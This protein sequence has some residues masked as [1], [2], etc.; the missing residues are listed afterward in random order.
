MSLQNVCICVTALAAACLT[1]TPARADVAIDVIGDYEVSFEGLLQ[2]DANWFDNDVVDLNGGGSG[3]GDDSE[4]ELRRAELI[5]KGKGT[6][7]DWVIG[8]DAKADKFLDVNARYKRGQSFFQLGQYK[9]PNSLEELS[10]TRHNDFIAKSMTTNL[11]GVGRR[12]GVAYGVD[13]GDYGFTVSAFDR[14]LTRNLA[15]GQGFGARG[16]FAPIHDDVRLLHLGL[17]AI[18][19]KTDADALRLRARPDAD[20][21]TARLIDTGSFTNTDRQ[22][23][24]GVEGLFVQG[25]FKLQGEYMHSRVKRD[26]VGLPLTQPA[27]DFDGS[28]W[29][30]Q[31]LWNLTG[32]TWGYKGGVP[33][34]PFPN[35]PSRGMWQL[36]ARVDAADL[37]DGAV[38]GGEAENLTLGVN[39]YWRSNFKVQLN[40]VL[41]SSERFSS[42]LGAEIDDD[43]NIVE[44]RLQFYW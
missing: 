30:L 11:F 15:E 38:F 36:A 14:E 34:V 3:N 37:D 39:W 13:T 42:A 5:L 10:S 19:A 43:P 40:Y 25:P 28:S 8:Y 27:D 29:Y 44:A 33:T 7:S 12:L 23:T 9:Q 41:A 1:A 21:A 24:L 22:T 26:D 18:N 31:G 17:S 6:S 20:L 35:E 4:F 16:W 2:A 32:E